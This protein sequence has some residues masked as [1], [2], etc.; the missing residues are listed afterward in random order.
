[1]ERTIPYGR[2]ALV[3]P[4]G[5]LFGHVVV[6]PEYVLLQRAAHSS[7]R[8]VSY[9]AVWSTERARAIA[10][11]LSALAHGSGSGAVSPGAPETLAILR[12]IAPVSTPL[13][14]GGGACHKSLRALM[15]R[16]LD[17]ELRAAAQQDAPVAAGRKFS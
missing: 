9:L 2:F 14:V 11:E 5:S 17:A 4:R 8:D 13:F 12:A 16:Q 1:M 10:L 7:I 3:E 6:A 15:R